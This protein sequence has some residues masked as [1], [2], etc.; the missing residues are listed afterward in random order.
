M[1]KHNKKRNVGIVYELLLKYITK[2]ILESNKSNAK[3]GTMIIEKHFH[4]KSELYKEFRLFNALAQSKVTNTH[5]VASILNEAKNAVRNNINYI[6]LEK[7]KS[8]LIR[9]INYNLDKDF[10]YNSVHNYRDLGAIQMTI[11]EWKKESPDLRRLV[12]FET[13]IAEIMLKEDVTPNIENEINA[14]H[15]DRL[16]LKIMTEK[17]NKKYNIDLT[18]EQKEIIKNYV[19]YSEKNKNYLQEY[20]T[21][22]KK[23]ALSALEEFEDK[24]ENSY[25][26]SKLD[27]V[28]KKINEV[29]T[30][31]ITDDNVIKFLSFTS[32][33]NELRKEE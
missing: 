20:F 3:K 18:S 6:K 24:S 31:L 15:S 4:K 11:N 32:L 12:E 27:K 29:N 5:V 14:S 7:E 21:N 26:L 16:V 2:N 10:Y 13:K 23:E 17:I 25:L 19:F 22:K 8:D 30:D 1:K 28:R 9:S 33:I